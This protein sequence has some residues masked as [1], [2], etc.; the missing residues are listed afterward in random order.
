MRARFGLAIDN[1]LNFSTTR[2]A[3][4]PQLRDPDRA[5]RGRRVPAGPADAVRYNNEP[6]FFGADA[7]V[8]LSLVADIMERLGPYLEPTPW[9]AETL[10]RLRDASS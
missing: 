6:Q 4:G 7:G 8:Y 2:T 1:A 5:R 3:P 9:R 10:T